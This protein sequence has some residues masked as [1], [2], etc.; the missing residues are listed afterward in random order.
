MD[1][2]CMCTLG[3]RGLFTCS[4]NKIFL[5]QVFLALFL[6]GGSFAKIC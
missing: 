1:F 6:Y 4:L 5:M 3:F 2:F